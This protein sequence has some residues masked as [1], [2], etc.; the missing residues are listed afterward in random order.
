MPPTPG[1]LKWR[2]PGEPLRMA[3]PLAERFAEVLLDRIA[4]DTHPSGTHMDMLE[5][6]APPTV[7]VQYVLHLMERIENDSHP[8]IP[9]MRRVQRVIA[10]FGA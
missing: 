1:R 8:S 10:E 3:N 6:I 5:A 7:R 9:M 2:Q 4:A